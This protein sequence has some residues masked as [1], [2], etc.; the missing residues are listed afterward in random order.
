MPL[1]GWLLQVFQL[2][3]LHILF[4]AK[5][6]LAAGWEAGSPASPQGTWQQTHTSSLDV[7][8]DLWHYNQVSMPVTA[9]LCHQ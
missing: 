7:F 8:S 2:A 9:A 6:F 4:V 3:A 5:A 1:P